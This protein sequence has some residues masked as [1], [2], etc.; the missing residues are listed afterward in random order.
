M[1]S[2]GY[3]TADLRRELSRFESE[4]RAA[5]LRESSVRTYVDRTAI[6]LRWL[7]GEYQPRGPN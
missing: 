1:N 4:L 3:S 7:D 5:G 6:F 2:E